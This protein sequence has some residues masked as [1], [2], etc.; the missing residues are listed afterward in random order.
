MVWLDHTLGVSS[1]DQSY[2]SRDR[3]DF[4]VVGSPVE[5]K[6]LID[7]K[8]AI[9]NKSRVVAGYCWDWVSKNSPQ[10]P[11]LVFPEFA[12][13][14]TWNLQSHGQGWLVQPDSHKQIGC[15]HTCQGLELDYVGVIIGPDLIYRDGELVTN[16]LARAKTDTSLKG[17]KK[18][19][20]ENPDS[21]SRKADEII[22]NTYR[23]LMSRGMKG[24][25]IW[26]SD[27]QTAE[28]FRQQL[29][30]MGAH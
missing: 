15:I 18:E 13:Q 7:E 14:A 19:F 27:Q 1:D 12:F 21:A 3:F 11:D 2:F 22:R 10:L 29:P 9:A 8:N 20:K 23:T 6:N 17:F 30:Q 28:Y 4:Q 24:C 25:Y 26:C 5:L 16:P